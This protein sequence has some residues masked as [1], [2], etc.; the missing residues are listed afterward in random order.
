MLICSMLICSMLKMF[1]AKATHC[2]VLCHYGYIPQKKK[3][4][5][6]P[7]SSQLDQLKLILSTFKI[8]MC[9]ELCIINYVLIYVCIGII[10]LAFSYL[11]S[12]PGRGVV[13][14]SR[15]Q[16]RTTRFVSRRLEPTYVDSTLYPCS[17]IQTLRYWTLAS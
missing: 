14:E 1:N 6:D 16:T 8:I 11:H 9:I 10:V 17:E 13:L 4:F 3:S 7:Y 5:I 12:Q 15:L 2:T